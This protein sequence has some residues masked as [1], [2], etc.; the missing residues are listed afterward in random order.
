MK[1]LPKGLTD[2]QKR[3]AQKLTKNSSCYIEKIVDYP[4]FGRALDVVHVHG[5]IRIY[6][7]GRCEWQPHGGCK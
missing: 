6:P 7:S 4:T 1:Y 3:V 2:E 5:R